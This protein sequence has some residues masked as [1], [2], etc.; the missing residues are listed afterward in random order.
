MAERRCGTCQWFRSSEY[1]Y[2]DCEYPLPV[3]VKFVLERSY[4][5]IF[6][7]EILSPFSTLPEYGKDCPTWQAKQEKRIG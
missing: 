6:P 3:W 7:L 1:A 5:N 4:S 2:G